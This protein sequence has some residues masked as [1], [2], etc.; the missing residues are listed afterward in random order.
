MDSINSVSFCARKPNIK[1]AEK[2][3]DNINEQIRGFHMASSGQ[4]P[5]DQLEIHVMN[6]ALTHNKSFLQGIKDGLA[7]LVNRK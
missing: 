1:K 5:K 3:M 2:V 4:V 6:A 7:S